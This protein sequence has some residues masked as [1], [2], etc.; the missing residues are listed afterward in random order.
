MKNYTLYIITFL[1]LAAPQ[2]KA[3]KPTI[4]ATASMFS[5]MAKNI[6]G[7]KM[8]IELIVP[9]GG[10]PHLYKPTPKDA[11]MVVNADLILKNGLTFEGWLDELIENSGTKA[12]VIL[13]TQGINPIKSLTYD[14]PD[15]HAWMNAQ[16]GLKY[17]ENI[18][19][20]IVALDPAN[21]DFYEKNY[22]TYS[23]EIKQLDEYILTQISKIPEAQ[24]I[25]VTSHDAFQYYG[26]RYGIQLESVLGTSTDADVQTQDILQL[27][28]IIRQSKVAAIFTETTINPKQM[29]QIA[30]DNG[31]VVGGSLYADSIGKPGSDGD[32]YI[33][34]LKANTDKI[35][36]GLTGKLSNATEAN[37]DN[38]PSSGFPLSAILIGL[39]LVGAM[40]FMFR[41]MNR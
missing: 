36:A 12:S 34:M 41:K 23:A 6:A 28:E 35:V 11:K 26:K 27:I 25:L 10:D 32:S 33:N 13:T 15:P 3:E 18:K 24:R 30:K 7:D 20:G 4:V 22:N 5:D 14:S 38:T 16:N 9:I 40:L 37:N 19:N 21:K 2:I 8:N 1:L 17:A 29:E 39:L 31:V